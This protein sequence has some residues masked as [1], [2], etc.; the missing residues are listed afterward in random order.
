[1][2]GEEVGRLL[3]ENMELKRQLKK[4]LAVSPVYCEG[5]TFCQSWQNTLYYCQVHRRY[6]APERYCSEGVSK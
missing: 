2:T 4:L 1:M 5:C 3:R 6:T